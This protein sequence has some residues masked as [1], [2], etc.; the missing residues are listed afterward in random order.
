MAAVTLHHFSGLAA[1]FVRSTRTVSGGVFS[2]HLVLPFYKSQ[3][4]FMTDGKSSR[5]ALDQMLIGCFIKF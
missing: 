4:V 3:N 2:R 1:P 5:P